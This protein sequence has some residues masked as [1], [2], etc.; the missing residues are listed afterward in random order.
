MLWTT[1]C[2]KSDTLDEMNQ[3]SERH[4]LPKLTKEE[5]DIWNR[6]ISIKENES[7]IKKIP[8]QKVPGPVG[9]TGEFYEIFN[10]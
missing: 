10:E 5:I 2:Y 6:S 7:I 3:F 8:K 9:F 4:N 1:L